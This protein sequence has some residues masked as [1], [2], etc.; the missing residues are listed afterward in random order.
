M[1]SQPSRILIIAGSDS[2]GGA[3]IQADIK[4][5]TMLGGYAMTAITAVTAQNSR[6]VTAVHQ[7]PCDMVL[8]QMEAVLAD[9]GADAV[10]IGM[11]GNAATA[12]AVAE[13]LSRSD[14]PPVI[15]DPV[16][17]ASSGAVLAED[18]TIDAFRE[19]IALSSLVTPNLP[20]YERLGGHDAM[21][22]TEAAWLVKGGHGE[23]D[24][25]SDRYYEAGR[26]KRVWTDRRID[27]SNTHGTGCVLSSAIACGVGEGMAIEAAIA[28]ARRFVRLSMLRAP[29]FVEVNGPLGIH[30]VRREEI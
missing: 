6:G 12:H 4:T 21:T 16:M 11:I 10:K 13:R 5:V 20:E 7:L 8:S 9:F 22:S 23:G 18:E 14:A 30:D 19:L 1:P 24:M 25:L 15:F 29:H 26:L 17:V 28:R 3:G 27:T 2:S